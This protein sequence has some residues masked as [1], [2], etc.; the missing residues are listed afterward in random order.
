[1]ASE[2]VRVFG[3]SLAV[4]RD[5]AFVGR[6]PELDVFR[7]QLAGGPGSR[8]VHYLHGPGGIGKS[9]LLRRFAREAAPTGRIVV[10]I[11]GRTVTPTPEGFLAAAGAAV[12][13]PP[14]V[15]LIDTFEK[16]QGLE[17]WL[18]ERFLPQLPAGTAVVIAG[19][20]APDPVA[21]ADPGWSGL[22]RITAL[23]NLEPGDAAEFLTVRGIAA[24]A[25]PALLGF[26]G[27]NP[28]ALALAAAVATG[29]EAAP[30]DWRPNQETIATLLARLVGTT[31]SPAHR[32]ALEICAHAY[33]TSESLLRAL[34][35]AQ[36]AELFAWLRS[37]PFIESTDTGLF[38]H[39]VVREALEADLKWRD[40]QGFAEMHGSL[41]DFHLQELRDAPEAQ[42]LARTGA[43]IFLYRAD[44][45]MSEFN[46]FREAGAVQDRA[47][48]P[49]QRALLLEMVRA[50]EGTASATIAAFW[51]DRQPEAFRV[52]HS[53]QTD[54]VIAFSA[55]LTST[56][57]EGADIDPVVAAAWAY[58][59]A[60][61][62]LRAGEHMAI[63]RFT[64]GSVYQRPSAPTTL[65]QWR[66]VGE[67]IRGERLAWSFIVMRDDGYWND[68]LADVGWDRIPG[69]PRV[70]E[71]EYAL[72]RHDW[73]ALPP[74]AWLQKKTDA[75]LAG[76][77]MLDGART[78]PEELIVLSRPEFAAAVREALRGF[79]KP[80]Q[81]SPLLYSRLVVESGK[82]LAEILTD[83]AQSLL[84]ER[85]GE[86]LHRAVTVSYFKGAPTQEVAAELLGLP[87]STYRRHLTTAVERIIELL[88]QQEL[89]GR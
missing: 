66:A 3:D 51:L 62:P 16:C 86:K 55:W 4:G 84:G 17:G 49:S 31:P 81:D 73:R 79:R 85:G 5:R 47:Y 7:D 52:Y 58:A 45:R 37:Q 57:P 2:G 50:A 27:G 78:G 12:R 21:T 61:G 35:G 25:Q 74:A 41:R 53:T 72:F 40:P 70:G 30:G 38:P 22:L 11:D 48:I 39:D 88:W 42:L 87:F 56:E 28:L 32:R 59:R 24:G 46:V 71:H 20:L 26:A 29:S 36:A 10:E 68:H 33:I 63:A 77:S 64:V 80:T 34:M 19:R 18:W 60:N 8:P 82:E 65:T 44:R 67:M 54:E 89:T 9:T 75:M 1:M 83:A 14:V 15:L 23:R 76:V 43:L 13:E 69:A 6:R